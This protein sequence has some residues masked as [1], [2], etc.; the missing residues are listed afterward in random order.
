MSAPNGVNVNVSHSI[1]DKLIVFDGA[2]MSLSAR[3]QTNRKSL[4]RWRPV[5]R[6][7][8]PGGSPAGGKGGGATVSKLADPNRIGL[9]VV[10]PCTD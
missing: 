10:D 3:R 9:A 5:K 4:G 8:E 2:P 7:W 6:W 1:C